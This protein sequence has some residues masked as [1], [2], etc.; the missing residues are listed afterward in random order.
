MDRSS[1][2]I[3]LGARSA[4]RGHLTA[5][6][7]AASL[8]SAAGR[9]QGGDPPAHRKS[10]AACRWADGRAGGFSE[11]FGLSR[12]QDRS[13]GAPSENHEQDEQHEENTE[14]DLRD[15]G[16]DARD[17]AESQE[18]RDYRN[19]QKDDRP[20]QHDE[21]LMKKLPGSSFSKFR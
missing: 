13:S 16:G 6:L 1:G 4:A 17:S 20:V 5:G 7:I 3:G 15:A 10:G 9:G 19:D 14:K 11:R 18:C 8:M 12:S 2:S 21:P